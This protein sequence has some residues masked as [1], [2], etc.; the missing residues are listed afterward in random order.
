M[1]MPTSLVE[2]RSRVLKSTGLHLKFP[3]GIRLPKPGSELYAQDLPGNLYDGYTARGF[4]YSPG[5]SATASY[6]KVRNYSKD[7]D[8]FGAAMIV[9]TNLKFPYKGTWGRNDLTPS[10]IKAT[11]EMPGYYSVAIRMT[12]DQYLKMFLNDTEKGQIDEKQ[13]SGYTWSLHMT[14]GVHYLVSLHFSKD[15][16]PQPVD[17]GEE[18]YITN[19]GFGIGSYWLIYCSVEDASK[20]LKVAI[21]RNKDGDYGDTDFPL[22]NVKQG[23][24]ISVHIR[25]T[26]GGFLV[27]TNFAKTTNFIP[28]SDKSNNNILPKISANCKIRRQL[29]VRIAQRAL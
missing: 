12:G 25:S 14:G 23:N 2:L 29:A 17:L 16:D 28:G 1:P 9:E 8:W 27:S 11:I 18:C 20:P 5:P 24:E 26:R 22:A 10:E 4:F 15:T 13:I 19:P 3:Y 6:F 21:K 7:T